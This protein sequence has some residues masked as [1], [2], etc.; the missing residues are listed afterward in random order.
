MYKT[1]KLWHFEP[2]TYRRYTIINLKFI[3][4][5]IRHCSLRSYRIFR[6]ASTIKVVPKK[7]LLTY[8]HYTQ[9]NYIKFNKTTKI[10]DFKFIIIAK[11]RINCFYIRIPLKYVDIQRLN[12]G[13]LVRCLVGWSNS[14]YKLFVIVVVVVFLLVFFRSSMY[15]HFALRWRK[16]KKW[17][18]HE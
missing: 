7:T 11:N 1:N 14:M 12:N 13:L 10:V 2:T 17:L 8:S 9:N 4:R 16:N 5:R 15:N 3:Y 6:W 18:T